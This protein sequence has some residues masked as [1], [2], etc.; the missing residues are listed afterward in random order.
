MEKCLLFSQIKI[1]I[2][3]EKER[4]KT[5]EEDTNLIALFRHEFSIF[6]Q[7]QYQYHTIYF[8]SKFS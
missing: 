8:L 4:K 1:R 2:I 7:N 5:I 3:D 6:V